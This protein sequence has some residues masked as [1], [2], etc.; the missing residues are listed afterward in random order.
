MGFFAGVDAF[1][2]NNNG[3]PLWLASGGALK[4]AMTAQRGSVLRDADETGTFTNDSAN[5]TWAGG[6]DLG[7][8]PRAL[9]LREPNSFAL[10]VHQLNAWV[11]GTGVLSSA[12]TG[13]SGSVDFIVLTIPPSAFSHIQKNLLP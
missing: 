11:A 6:S 12:Y 10:E 7:G 5:F 8:S 13:K 4:T 9:I 1:L 3:G 2:P